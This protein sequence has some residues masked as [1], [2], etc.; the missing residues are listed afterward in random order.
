VVIDVVK[1]LNQTVVEELK[2]AKMDGKLT[3]DE[4]KQ[5]KNKAVELVLKRLGIDMIKIIQ[6]SL[7]SITDLLSTKIEAAVFDHKKSQ[8]VHNRGEKVQP[9]FAKVR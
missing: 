7:G 2:A 9:T 5:I 6:T 4:A 8:S 3:K 1:E